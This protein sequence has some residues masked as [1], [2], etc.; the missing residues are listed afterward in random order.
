MGNRAHLVCAHPGGAPVKLPWPARHYYHVYAAGS[1]AE[2]VREHIEALGESAFPGPVTIGLA[3]PDG[4]RFRA[5]ELISMRMEAAG[6]PPPAGWIE[7][8]AGFEQV[9]LKVVRADARLLAL[10]PGEAAILYAHTK[11]ARDNSDW[12]AAWRRSMTFHVVSQWR[13]AL[14]LLAGGYDTVGCHW[15]TPEKHH[16][17]PAGR[18]ITT[19]MY[20][21]N[22]WWAK[23][24]YLRRLPPVQDQHRYQ[25]EE[26]V[27]LAA[28][29]ACDLLPGWPTMK[30]LGLE[31]R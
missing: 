13:H 8:P 2:P 18:I 17:P 10:V 25:A 12:N 16:D 7:A 30:L 5:R 19:P 22:F 27:G 15:L 28:P 6:L 26:W 14:S 20:G 29:R 4:D 1:W 11:G 23:A 21:G 3:G 24:S 31:T 9:T